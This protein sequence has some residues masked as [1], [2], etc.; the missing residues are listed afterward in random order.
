MI[1]L[2]S[3]VAK[4]GK[5]Y[6]ARYLLEHYNVSHFSTDYLM[7]SLSLGN[8]DLNI[9]HNADDAVVAKK[10]EPY[11]TAMIAA[12]VQ[13]KTHYLIEG[14]HFN[15]DFM[16]R[17]LEKH[18]GK[19]KA[20]YLGYEQVDV[21]EKVAELI[22]YRDRI[23]NCWYRNFPTDEMIKLVKYMISV[24]RQIHQEADRYH[25]PYIDIYDIVDQAPAIVEQLME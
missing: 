7:M 14:V 25:I 17:L 10:L 24:S 5:S 9:D 21:M 3:G 16:N 8:P 11:L 22:K 6:V 13:N 23:E 1:Y 15:P 2:L 19:V 12:M 18:P 20:L 4:S